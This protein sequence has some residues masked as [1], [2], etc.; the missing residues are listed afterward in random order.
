MLKG[1]QHI[2]PTLG[3]KKTPNS[4]SCQLICVKLHHLLPSL[5]RRQLSQPNL[6]NQRLLLW[7]QPQRRLLFLNGQLSNLK[8]LNLPHKLPLNLCR[9][10]KHPH[11]ALHQHRL[12]HNL[13]L[14]KLTQPPHKHLHLNHKLRQLLQQQRRVRRLPHK[15]PQFGS[16]QITLE[17]RSNQPQSKCQKHL[18]QKRRKLNHLQLPL[19]KHKLLKPL[20]QHKQTATPTRKQSRTMNGTQQLTARADALEAN[21][22]AATHKPTATQ[23]KT[24]ALLHP[25]EPMLLKR[26]MMTTSITLL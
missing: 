8:N 24:V 4:G 23:M 18:P 1:T 10:P 26:L 11:R 13:S 6:K 20:N 16:R 12:L 21:Q 15:Q 25:L 2:T 14:K 22:A 17:L 19:L 7:L 5:F 9:K 3:E